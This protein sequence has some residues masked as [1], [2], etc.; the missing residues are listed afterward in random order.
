[1]VV[2]IISFTSRAFYVSL[3]NTEDLV[4]VLCS[5]TELKKLKLNLDSHFGFLMEDVHKYLPCV[6]RYHRN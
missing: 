6:Q 1:M 4:K 5:L 2:W 3:T